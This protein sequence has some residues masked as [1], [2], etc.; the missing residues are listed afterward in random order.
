MK[1]KEL[2]AIL[3]NCD[4]DAEVHFAAN[5][6]SPPLRTVIATVVRE[7]DALGEA[8]GEYRRASSLGTART[9]VVIG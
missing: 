2:I 8:R 7:H 6:D 3:K 9:K 5:V 1:V 4:K